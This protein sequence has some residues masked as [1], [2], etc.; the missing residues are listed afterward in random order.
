MAYTSHFLTGYGYITP[1]TSEG[2]ILC[3]FVAFLGIPITMLALKSVGELI[4]EC[5]NAIV[6]KFEKKIL[7]KQEPKGVQTKS[8]VILFSL[9][10]MLI[11]SFALFIVNKTDMSLVECI[12]FWF[13]TFTTIGFGDYVPGKIPQKINQLSVNSSRNHENKRESNEE[14]VP[15]YI[16][17]FF[18]LFC[19]FGFCVVSSVLNSIMVVF[20]VEG[21]RPRCPGCIPR[22]IG[23]HVDNKEIA[24]EQSGT[25]ITNLNMENTGIEKENVS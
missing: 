9:M 24:A 22:K 1:Q 21:Y 17:I 23:D 4:V 10:V 6:M 7:K 11:I 19:V 20:Q 16:T 18:L 2:Q 8:A 3:I 15:L 12:Y 14:T 25:K 5:V 13:I